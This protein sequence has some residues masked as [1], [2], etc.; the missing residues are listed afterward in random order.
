MPAPHA[1]PQLPPRVHTLSGFCADAHDVLVWLRV[2]TSD[3]L[4]WGGL[5]LDAVA[6]RLHAVDMQNTFAAVQ[7]KCRA[8]RVGRFRSAVPLLQQH[9]SAV[10]ARASPCRTRDFQYGSRLAL[11]S[12]PRNAVESVTLYST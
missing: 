4:A 2:C 3:P 7:T 6:A 8:L 12:I 10:H 9:S 5:G 1:Q 11:R